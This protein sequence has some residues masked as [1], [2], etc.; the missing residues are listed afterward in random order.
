MTSLVAWSLCEQNKNEIKK[1]D[2]KINGL[3]IKPYTNLM[4]CN[5][6]KII[7]WLYFCL[8]YYLTS[9]SVLKFFIYIVNEKC[10]LNNVSTTF[11]GFWKVF[12]S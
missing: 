12:I 1:L 10:V 7:K 3:I 8:V 4:K 5:V 2:K 11:S 6:W 9:I